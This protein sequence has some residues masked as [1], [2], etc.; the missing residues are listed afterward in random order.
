MEQKQITAVVK[1]LTELF[2]LNEVN[3]FGS[4][5]NKN[6]FYIDKRHFE[7]FEV[8]SKLQEYFRDKVID[9]GYLSVDS[10]TFVFTIF[11]VKIGKPELA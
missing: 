10:V 1:D 7:R 2:S 11:E 4:M 6:K 8:I 5:V 3:E 9:G